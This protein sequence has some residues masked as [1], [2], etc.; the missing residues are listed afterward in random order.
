MVTPNDFETFKKLLAE[1]DQTT[2]VRL[3][4]FIARKAYDAREQENPFELDDWS[5]KAWL[6][7]WEL[8]DF[9]MRAIEMF[10]YMDEN[11]EEFNVH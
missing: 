11:W 10:D 6:E 5:G 3:F 7:G 9:E 8:A 1:K 4:G 2:L